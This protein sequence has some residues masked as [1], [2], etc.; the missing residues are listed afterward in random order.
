MSVL[1]QV[2]FRLPFCVPALPLFVDDEKGG[3]HN[4]E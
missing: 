3:D 2:N 1:L 4:Q